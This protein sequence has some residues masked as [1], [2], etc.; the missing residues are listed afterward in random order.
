M[1]Y[2]CIR[3]SDD[4]VRE[5]SCM[6]IHMICYCVGHKVR[7]TRVRARSEVLFFDVWCIGRLVEG[8]KGRR[9]EIYRTHERLTFAS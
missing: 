2:E 5:N 4:L 6:A 7:L 1:P 8:L 3:K 9:T